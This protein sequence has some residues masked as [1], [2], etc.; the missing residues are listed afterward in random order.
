MQ[1]LRQSVERFR[2]AAGD[3]A[4][5]TDCFFMKDQRL[6]YFSMITT[7][8]APTAIAAQE[9]RIECMYPADETT[10][11]AHLKLM[12]RSSEKSR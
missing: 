11:V 10:E 9:L 5:D 4:Y 6:N 3:A 1:R 7:V 2:S 12:K 8:G